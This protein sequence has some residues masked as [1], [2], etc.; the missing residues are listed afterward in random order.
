MSNTQYAFAV[1]KVRQLENNLL[2]KAQFDQMI[3]SADI[4]EALAV[5]SQKGWQTG[6]NITDFDHLLN[7]ELNNTWEL[8]NELAPDSNELK[9]IVVKNDFHNLKVAVK[10][11]VS[12]VSPQQ[13][14]VYPT[15]ADTANI[16]QNLSDKDYDLLPAYLREAAAAA[17]DAVTLTHDGQLAEVIIDKAALQTI[18]D[19]AEKGNSEIVKS[20]AALTVLAADIKTAVRGAKAG[21]KEQFFEQAICGSRDINRDWFIKAAVRGV[22]EVLNFLTA[23]GFS[24]Y[25]EALK[26]SLSAFEKLCDEKIAALI[27]QAALTSF[28]IDPIV[29]YYLAKE[30]EIKNVRIILICKNMGADVSV[31]AERVREADV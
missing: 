23:A 13:Y 4:S 1:A 15:F 27:Y 31:I 7:D 6:E 2:S 9:A 22:D 16:V 10:A 17:Y 19:F 20:Y 3:N 8:V 28:G 5:L 29:A 26:V 11:L 30:N 25:T 18:T 21:K 14:F 12:G 24:E